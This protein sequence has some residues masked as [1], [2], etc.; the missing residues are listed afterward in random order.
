MERGFR[1]HTCMLYLMTVEFLA[2]I[3]PKSSTIRLFSQAGM[4]IGKD[5]VS[6]VLSEK[7]RQSELKNSNVLDSLSLSSLLPSSPG[8]DQTLHQDRPEGKAQ[9]IL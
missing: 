8:H 6:L 1:N 3:N 9:G 4:L 2:F 5:G 7:V